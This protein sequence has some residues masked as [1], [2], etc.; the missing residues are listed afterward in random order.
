M[1]GTRPQRPE[2]A[3][4]DPA[5]TADVLLR[6]EPDEDDEDEPDKDHKDNEENEADEK[7]DEG[8]YSV[9]L[10]IHQGDSRVGG[11]WRILALQHLT[12]FLQL[13]IRQNSCRETQL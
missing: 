8:G 1:N 12:L 4:S 5:V 2:S 9:S 7:D 6:E 3:S 13:H 11:L 10:S